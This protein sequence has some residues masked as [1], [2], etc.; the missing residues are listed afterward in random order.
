M[1]TADPP[2]PSPIPSPCACCGSAC[3]TERILD[4]LRNGGQ[5]FVGADL[6]TILQT[7][8][9]QANTHSL[10]DERHLFQ[11]AALPR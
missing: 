4:I 2:P 9:N 6:E 11:S 7:A 10:L 3:V 1:P 5:Q 8:A